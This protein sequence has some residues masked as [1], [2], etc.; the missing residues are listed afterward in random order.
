MRVLAYLHAHFSIFHHDLHEI[1][2]RSAAA[3]DTNVAP[4]QASEKSYRKGY[5]P[6]FAKDSRK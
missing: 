6:N 2:R 1:D 4:F 3:I 5:C